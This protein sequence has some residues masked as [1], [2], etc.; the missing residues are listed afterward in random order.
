MA[1][2]PAS[3][4]RRRQN[5]RGTGSLLRAELLDAAQ[6]LLI[7]HGS[8][9]A[10]TVQAV[11]DEVGCTPPAL[12]RHFADK[13]ELVLAVC[14]RLFDAYRDAVAKAD[15][16]TRDPRNRLRATGN[17]YIDFALANPGVYRVLFMHGPSEQPRQASDAAPTATMFD[18]LLGQ[19]GACLPVDT[20]TKQVFAVAV[21]V[22]TTVHGVVSL[23]IS[24]PDFPWPGS[25]ASAFAKAHTTAVVD[26]L[27]ASANA[28]QL[29]ATR[30]GAVKQL[31]DEAERSRIA[32]AYAAGY[33][34]TGSESDGFGA[35]ATLHVEA[36]AERIA[37]RAGE[38]TW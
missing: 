26:A 15:R 12:Y 2:P 24:K 35:L 34:E 3:S 38:K 20:S 22:W 16:R 5:V 8:R 18:H 7:E 25:S 30:S 13:Q 29:K 14:D 17:A 1:S 32:A 10:V 19:V 21:S 37:A 9:D 27:L 6:R 31:V 36:E 23:M 11:C 4:A 28:R 33:P